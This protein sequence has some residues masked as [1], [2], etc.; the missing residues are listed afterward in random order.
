MD[1]ATTSIGMIAATRACFGWAACG[2][3]I[4]C[5]ASARLRVP[6]PR[7]PSAYHSDEPPLGGA[8]HSA[9]NMCQGESPLQGHPRKILTIHSPVFIAACKESKSK[10]AFLKTILGREGKQDGS[11]TCFMHCSGSMTG[12]PVGCLPIGAKSGSLTSSD[13][14]PAVGTLSLERR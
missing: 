3:V 12:E 8:S 11:L 9:S 2:C 6:W 4:S 5:G 1:S 13:L 7:S 14:A 10:F